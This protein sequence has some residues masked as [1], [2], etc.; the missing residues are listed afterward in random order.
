MPPLVI[1]A[2]RRIIVTLSFS[3]SKPGKR[4]TAFKALKVNNVP[5]GATVTATCV[6]GCSRKAFVARNA[7]RTVSLERLIDRG[8]LKAGTKV[9]VVVSMSR[10]IAAVQTLTVRAHRKPTV[11]TRCLPPGATADVLC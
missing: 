8:P 4:S 5:A 9:R 6:K 1:P 10:T 11:A 3:T 2:V 7:Y